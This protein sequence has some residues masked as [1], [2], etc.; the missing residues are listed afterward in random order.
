MGIVNRSDDE[1]RSF[2]SSSSHSF[3]SLSLSLSILFPH[4]I[5]IS[6]T[7]DHI[8]SFSLCP[9]VHLHRIVKY[10]VFPFPIS[11][12]GSTSS[13]CFPAIQEERSCTILL[14]VE[15]TSIHFFSFPVFSF[16]KPVNSRKFYRFV[17]G[18]I[19]IYIYRHLYEL[20]KYMSYEKIY[21]VFLNSWSTR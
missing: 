8:H 20:K 12:S 15:E 4:S 14:L 13:I 18:Y 17:D 16:F 9:S 10:R 2:S 21:I 3:I 1:N 6:H 7:R 5:V 11:S 19:Y